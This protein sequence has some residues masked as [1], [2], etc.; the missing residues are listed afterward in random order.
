M[1]KLDRRLVGN[2]Y[3]LAHA[4]GLIE[5]H[6]VVIFHTPEVAKAVEETVREEVKKEQEALNKI[7]EIVAGEAMRGKKR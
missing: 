7:I 3:A 1:G 5:P 6:S 4:W 2:T